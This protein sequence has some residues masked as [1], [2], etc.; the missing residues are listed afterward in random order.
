MKTET[1]TVSSFDSIELRAFGDMNITQGDKTSL[2]IEGDQDTL[3]KIISRVEG[4]KLILELGQTLLQEQG[5]LTS[6]H[7][8]QSF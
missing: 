6:L 2:M 5:K 8:R 4:N 3:Q 1:R 7:S